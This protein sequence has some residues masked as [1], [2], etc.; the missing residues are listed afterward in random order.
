MLI[1]WTANGQHLLLLYLTG[2]VVVL[3]VLFLLFLELRTSLVSLASTIV[4]QATKQLALHL[5]LICLVSYL[6]IRLPTLFALFSF[7]PLLFL[8]L[9]FLTHF[10]T[11]ALHL[12]YMHSFV[13][14]APQ[15][16]TCQKWWLANNTHE[17]IVQP[18]DDKWF[19]STDC[20][21]PALCVRTRRRLWDNWGT[22]TVW[23]GYAA[24]AVSARERGFHICVCLCACECW[25]A[26]G[27]MRREWQR[28]LREAPALVY[29]CAGG[30]EKRCQL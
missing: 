6:W 7:F 2:F 27:G 24:L 23:A 8:L 30:E 5:L 3:L 14:A 18:T 10:H 26:H 29:I 1:I 12:R 25:R 22:T 20:L 13:R 28:L 9:Q 16:I 21:L 19:H 4:K 11:F 17:A 15:R